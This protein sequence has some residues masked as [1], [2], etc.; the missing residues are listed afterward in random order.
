MENA[1]SDTRL[2]ASRYVSI[3]S[4]NRRACSGSQ[5]SL[6]LSTFVT[7]KADPPYIFLRIRPHLFNEKPYR[8]KTL[9]RV[10]FLL[11]IRDH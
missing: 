8:L 3:S 4:S 9:K 7:I 2:Q 10:F 1:Y 5:E 6:N 11:Q